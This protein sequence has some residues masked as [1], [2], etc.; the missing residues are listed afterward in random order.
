MN[1]AQLSVLCIDNGHHLTKKYSD[2]PLQV[3]FVH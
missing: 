2:S 1:I 3:K